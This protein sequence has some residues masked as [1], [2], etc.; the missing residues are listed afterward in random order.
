MANYQEV[1]STSAAKDEAWSGWVVLTAGTDAAT[2]TINDHASAASG[3]VALIIKA[4][5]NT[6]AAPPMYIECDN[7]A[8]VTLAGTSPKV[9]LFDRRG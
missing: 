8:Y 1:T 7:G 6:T 9:Y 4:V 5:A 3:S 2:C